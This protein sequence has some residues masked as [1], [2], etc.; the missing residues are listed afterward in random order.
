MNRDVETELVRRAMGGDDGARMV[1][2]S[3]HRRWLAAVLLARMPSG[4]DL[5]DLLQEV[6]MRFVSQIHTLQDPRAWRAWLRAVALNVARSAGRRARTETAVMKPLILDD[7][8]DPHQEQEQRS[9]QAKDRAAHVLDLIGRL[10]PDYREPLLLRCVRGLTQR[11]V[12]EALDLPVTT[13]ETR[14]ARGRRMLRRELAENPPDEHNP[15][16]P[17]L[18]PLENDHD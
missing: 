16:Q 12:A 8:P 10:Q 14:L 18:L 11:Q 5:E 13:V 3:S 15:W 4:V 17:E 1:L 2:W 6:A 7:I 9:K